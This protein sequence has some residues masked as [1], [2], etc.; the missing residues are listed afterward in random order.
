M[1]ARPTEL[2]FFD[3]EFAE[4]GR[5]IDLISIGVVNE[6]RTR[7]YYAV[8]SEFDREACN[9]WVKVNVLPKLGDSKPIARAQ[10]AIDL[11]SLF[12]GGETQPEIWGYFADY[13]WVVLCQLFGRMIDLPQ[14]MPMFCMDL[15]QFME[16]Q[17]VA[18]ADLADDPTDA[19]N[20]L[21]D[22]EWIRAAHM[23]V[24][25]LTP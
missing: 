8:S 22:A 3:T 11:K 23:R 17:A 1:S 16:D 2:W 5:T 18:R 13:D 12:L 15:K 7:S 20:A 25:D 24:E 21:A 4:N 14:G 9:D 19:H 6:A 10:I